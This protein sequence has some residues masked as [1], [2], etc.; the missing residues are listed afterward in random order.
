MTALGKTY[1]IDSFTGTEI[2][3]STE[4]GI[5]A[6]THVESVAFL[7][8]HADNGSMIALTELQVWVLIGVFASAIFGMIAWQNTTFART[9]STSIK[10][11]ERQVVS[12]E[13][14]VVSV[15]KQIEVQIGSVEKQIRSLHETMDSRMDRLHDQVT[16][17][18]RDVQAITARVFREDTP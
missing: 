12:V 16:T 14:Q 1:L 5:G 8:S 4:L 17:L 13:K 6:R 3:A 18:D 10:S 2:S 9:L 11:V 15:E 7:Y